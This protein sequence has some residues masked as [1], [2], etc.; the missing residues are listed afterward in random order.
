MCLAHL[1]ANSGKIQTC[2][3][4]YLREPGDISVILAHFR[5]EGY[6]QDVTLAQLLYVTGESSPEHEFS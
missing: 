2:P 1:A 3:H 4:R 6:Q 5:N